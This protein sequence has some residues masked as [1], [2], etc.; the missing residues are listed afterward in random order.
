MRG[1]GARFRPKS[2]CVLWGSGWRSHILL[3]SRWT[4]GEGRYTHVPQNW[5][6]SG[7]NICRDKQK[8][9]VQRTTPL[10]TCC[11]AKNPVCGVTYGDWQVVARCLAVSHHTAAYGGLTPPTMPQFSSFVRTLENQSSHL[12]E[13]ALY[14]NQSCGPARTGTSSGMCGEPLASI[15]ASIHA[16][17]TRGRPFCAGPRCVR[18]FARG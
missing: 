15:P 11:G 5:P 3:R 8:S 2:D 18:T 10:E 14:L 13:R 1:R 6:K 9:V 17:S 4:V 12:W 7:A 16:V